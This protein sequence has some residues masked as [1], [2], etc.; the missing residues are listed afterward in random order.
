MF[1]N[2]YFLIKLGFGAFRQIYFRDRTRISNT[3]KNTIAIDDILLKLFIRNNKFMQ[4]TLKWS[5]VEFL[6][7]YFATLHDFFATLHIY[8]FKYLQKQR[9]SKL[10]FVKNTVYETSL[11]RWLIFFLFDLQRCI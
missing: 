11:Q 9:S 8:S 3:R 6:E 7:T 2:K 4:I 5:F 10:Y 1:R